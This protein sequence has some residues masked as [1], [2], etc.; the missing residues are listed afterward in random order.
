MQMVATNASVATSRPHRVVVPP[1]RRCAPVVMGSTA[2]T[3]GCP[4]LVGWSAWSWPSLFTLAGLRHGGVRLV[5][6]DGSGVS[7]T[8]LASCRWARCP[9]VGPGVLSMGPVS[10][11]LAYRFVDGP[12]V[13][14]MGLPLRRWGCRFVDGHGV[15]SIGSVSRRLACCL[16]DGPLL[17]SSPP[18]RCAVWALGVVVGVSERGGWRR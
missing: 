10:C 8:G 15:S 1:T 13:P 6:V 11:R 16:V 9:V 5:W 18:R 3:L 17:W 14:S 4:H 2:L 7:S 12:G